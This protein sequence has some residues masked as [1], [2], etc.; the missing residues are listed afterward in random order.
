MKDKYYIFFDID[1]TIYAP[2]VGVTEDA[3]YTVKKLKEKGHKVF[4]CTGRSRAGIEAEITD[5]DFDGIIAACGLY[6]EIDGKLIKNVLLSKEKIK[7][8]SEEIN[9]DDN[10]SLIL[11][12]SENIYVN[13]SLLDEYERKKY[14]K[15]IENNRARIRGFDTEIKNINKFGIKV[16]DKASS[17]RIVKLS[18]EKGFDVVKHYDNSYEAVPYGYDKAKGIEEVLK[19]FNAD[20]KK[21]IAVGDSINDLPMLKLVDISI[22]P[23]NGSE[24]AKKYGS[25]IT[26]DILDFGLKKAFMRLGFI[27][28]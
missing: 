10:L 20:L 7:W 28:E 5:L 18:R 8:I 23:E 1:G 3:K 19:Y 22:V 12:G 24:I 4:I 9:N 15:F 14:S 21:A 2:S 13:E 6:I 27:D 26:E 11:E 17:K 16:K 25:V